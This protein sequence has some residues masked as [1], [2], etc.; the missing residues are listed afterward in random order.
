VNR[1]IDCSKYGDKKGEENGKS[2]KI[3]PKKLGT[4]KNNCG[5]ISSDVK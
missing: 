1:G 5:V 4:V 3:K 2:L